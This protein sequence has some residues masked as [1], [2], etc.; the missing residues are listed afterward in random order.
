MTLNLQLSTFFLLNF[1]I[2]HSLCFICCSCL[3]S[4]FPSR[5][6][7]HQRMVD[8]V[9]P[10]FSALIPAEP[11]FVYKYLGE[12]SCEDWFSVCTFSKDTFTVK[13]SSEI[14]STNKSMLSIFI[15]IWSDWNVSPASQRRCQVTQYP[16]LWE[17]PSRTGRPMKR[18][19]PSSK[20]CPTPTRK[21]TM[22]LFY[23]SGRNMLPAV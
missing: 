19:C 6:S 5:L 16:S 20:T 22:V 23:L 15:W 4:L 9:P 21:T 11:L 3:F 13:S 17:T 14:I 10:T 18:S 12:S 7:Y 1:N 8:I 2:L